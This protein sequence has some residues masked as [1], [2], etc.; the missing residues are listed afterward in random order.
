MFYF[1]WISSQV[2][3]HWPLEEAEF[4]WKETPKCSKFNVWSASQVSAGHNQ[5][6]HG[7]GW[8]GEEQEFI[9]KNAV[10]RIWLKGN[11]FIAHR[12]HATHT[13]FFQGGLIALIILSSGPTSFHVLMHI[14][15]LE[16]LNQCCSSLWASQ[17]S[18]SPAFSHTLLLYQ[19]KNV[20]QNSLSFLSST[21]PRVR[22][23]DDSKNEVVPVLDHA[24]CLTNAC[25]VVAQWLLML[26]GIPTATNT[27][28]RRHWP[29]H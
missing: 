5:P 10:L 21:L 23:L 17:V 13:Q 11:T 28:G 9:L 12:A 24:H 1:E 22:W 20:W 26:S 4:G 7:T 29:T 6:V 2:S 19:E 8:R 18:T 14:R 25:I 3:R 16:A 15:P 27:T